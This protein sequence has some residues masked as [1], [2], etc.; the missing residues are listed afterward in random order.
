MN[1]Q[2][3]LDVSV[4][5]PAKG[6]MVLYKRLEQPGY[7]QWPVNFFSHIILL[8]DVPAGN[9]EG[10]VYSECSP[11][12]FT[13]PVH[14]QSFTT[15][16]STTSTTST[17]TSTTSTTT[18]TTTPTSTTSTTST[19]TTTST[20]TT[21][22]LPTVVGTLTVQRSA[23]SCGSQG[24]SVFQFNFPTPTPVAMTFQVGWC[25]NPNPNYPNTTTVDCRGTSNMGVSTIRPSVP[26]NW[27]IYGWFVTVPAGS[28][29][30]NTGIVLSGNGTII[31]IY[32]EC[33]KMYQTGIHHL[34]FKKLNSGYNVNLNITNHDIALYVV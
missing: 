32:P 23:G 33:N 24:A 21:T 30:Y 16:T 14:W 15:T 17:T 11:G 2:I 34:Y 8:E 19:S 31:P 20:T 1:I 7:T 9:Y 18:T 6:F 28:T 12:Q 10:Y 3:F 13:S 22:T 25:N 27:N 4:P 5:I 26:G 29:S